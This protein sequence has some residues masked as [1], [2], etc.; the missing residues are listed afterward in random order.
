MVTVIIP[1][2]IGY[3]FTCQFNKTLVT[4]IFIK[5]ACQAASHL[6]SSSSQAM[7]MPFPPP[8]AEALIITG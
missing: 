5:S 1:L 4:A 6:V 2:C 7:R 8:P 3:L